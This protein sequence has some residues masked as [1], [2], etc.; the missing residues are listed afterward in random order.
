MTAEPV[1]IQTYEKGL[2]K[3][4]AATAWDIL[5]SCILC[6]RRCE[7]DRQ[8]GQ[9]GVCKTGAKALVSSYTPHFGEE[10]P[11][12]G[13]GGSG[14][15]FF[16]HCNL[17]CVFCQ[18]FDISHEGHGEEVTSEQLADMMLQL[19]NL[20]SHNINFVTPSHVVPHILQALEFAVEA[21]LRVPLVY[22]SSAYDSVETL[23]ILDGV[24][25]I[26]M[27]DFKFWSSDNAQRSCDAEDYPEVARNAL[28]EMHRQAGDL[29]I[30]SSGVARR[31]LLIRHLVMPS[32]FSGTREVMRFIAQNVS[33]NS[34][35]N[36]MPQ[37]MPCGRA[38][39]I[40]ELREPL[41]FEE[42]EAAL[43]AAASEGITRIDERRRVFIA[44]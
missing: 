8:S 18:N 35:V 28:M 33:A 15:I 32:N 4:K 20:G 34:Y 12:V 14:T 5:A 36:V 3:E 7:V 43:Q 13:S 16:T 9:T 41:S 17:L 42:F 29:E 21:G 38:S 40:E 26:Y 37:Y 10:E 2:L 19:Q 39:E 24:I 11:L 23:K 25:D 6:P 30:D 31:G 1:Y 27:P 44:R 22:N